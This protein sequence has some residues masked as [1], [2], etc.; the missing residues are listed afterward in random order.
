MPQASSP[1]TLMMVSRLM[2]GGFGRLR[3]RLS[4]ER[5]EGLRLTVY[6]MFAGDIHKL[7]QVAR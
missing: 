3:I 6:S 5:S 4:G 7:R 2:F 1:S